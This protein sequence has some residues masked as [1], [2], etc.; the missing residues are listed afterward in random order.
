MLGG[1]QYF[2]NS[3]L[4]TSTWDDC[5]SYLEKENIGETRVIVLNEKQVLDIEKEKRMVFISR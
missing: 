2:K 3:Y 1:K 5:K 4:G